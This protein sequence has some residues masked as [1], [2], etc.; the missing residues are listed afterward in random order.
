MKDLLT[1]AKAA[2]RTRGAFTSVAYDTIKRKYKIVRLSKLAYSIAAKLWDSL[3]D[4]DRKKAA[5]E[6][7]KKA[8]AKSKKS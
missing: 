6:K 4:K 5:K 8:V 7:G 1:P 3:P 2:E